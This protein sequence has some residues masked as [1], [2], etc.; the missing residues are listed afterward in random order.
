MTNTKTTNFNFYT[1]NVKLQKI[2]IVNFKGFRK[3]TFDFDGN[4][5]ISGRNASG[6]STIADAFY[7][8]LFGTD[9]NQSTKLTV[10]RVE[11]G[12]E[13]LNETH[14]V[15]LTMRIDDVQKIYERQLLEVWTRPAGTE[16]KTL[17][18]HKTR[19]LINDCEV[20]LSAFDKEIS[21]LICSKD[22]FY[23][24]SNPATFAAL[25]TDQ[26]RAIL[27]KLSTVKLSDIAQTKDE[28]KRLFDE[29][30]GYSLDT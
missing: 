30:K 23:T 13:V 5:T 6:K 26:Q 16:E 22:L 14:S 12:R 11:N 19:C 8:C 18:A 9:A 10:K 3:K 7:W 24:L 4:V 27:F 1:M 15:R 28:Y 21:T 20:T 17:T 25:K 2:D 29:L